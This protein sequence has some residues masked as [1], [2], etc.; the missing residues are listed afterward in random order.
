[1]Y[2]FMATHPVDSLHIAPWGWRL[3]G[4]ALAPLVSGSVT[5]GFQVLAVGARS[6]T[7]LAM[8]PV[9]RRVGFDRRLA[10]LGADLFLSLGYAIHES[11][12]C[13]EM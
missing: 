5:V 10:L 9:A 3:L 2:G 13:S 4:P 12:A 7:A 8:Y 6:L 11:G 1:M